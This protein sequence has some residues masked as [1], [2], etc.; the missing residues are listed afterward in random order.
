MKKTHGLSRSNHPIYWAWANMKKRCYNPKAKGYADYGGRGIK[1]CEQWQDS[2]NFIND[3]L[4]TWQ[5]GLQLDRIDNNGD[6]EPDNCKWSTKSEQMSNRRGYGTV[7][8]RGVNRHMN[9]KFEAGIRINGKRI[10]LGLFDTAEEAGRAYQ[11][12]RSKQCL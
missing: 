8:Y 5:P 12:Y 2:V 9:G 6:Y 7:P 1:V 3:M 10:Y 4:P 11:E